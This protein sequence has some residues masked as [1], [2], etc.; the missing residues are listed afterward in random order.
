MAGHAAHPGRRSAPGTGQQRAVDLL[1]HGNAPQATG[2]GGRKI[3]AGRPLDV[4][5]HPESLAAMELLAEPGVNRFVRQGKACALRPEH[6]SFGEAADTACTIG[7][8]MQ[9]TAYETNGDESF[10][11]GRVD[12]DDWVIRCHGMRE[13]QVG[14]T[15]ALR[16]RPADIVSF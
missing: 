12:H 13:V 14:G 7:F 10:I 8:D 5:R 2:E 3:Q 4:Y 6:V 9:V 11:H 16:A 1:D 15:L